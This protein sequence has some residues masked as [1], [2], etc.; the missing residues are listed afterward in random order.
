MKIISFALFALLAFSLASAQWDIDNEIQRYLSPGEDYSTLEI[1]Y[2]TE[3]ESVELSNILVLVND[4]PVFIITGEGVL[5]ED[6][7]TILSVVN[8]YIETGGENLGSPEAIAGAISIETKKRKEKT[9]IKEASQAA[10]TKVK[11]M[12]TKIENAQRLLKGVEFRL[13]YAE[14]NDFEQTTIDIG[15]A[16]SIEEASALN[17]SFYP[18]FN[19]FSKFATALGK[20]SSNLGSA[21]NE[22]REARLVLNEKIVTAGRDDPVVVESQKELSEVEALLA[23]EVEKIERLSIPSSA[24]A[25]EAAKKSKA[26]LQRVRQIQGSGANLLSLAMLLLAI[27][28]IGGG[29]VFYFKKLR[30]KQGKEEGEIPPEGSISSP[31]PE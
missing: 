30:E 27:V 3:N 19:E 22:T 31:H 14:L 20:V 29:V 21:L 25:S 6:D 11:Q 2:Q 5:V 7:E 17:S 15:L 10:L 1:I 24:N 26:L 23:E 4:A 12:R 13:I 18:E 8:D 28:I 9:V 16:S